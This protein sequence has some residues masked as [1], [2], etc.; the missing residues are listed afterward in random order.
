MRCRVLK[1]VF[2]AAVLYSCDDS[3][4]YFQSINSPPHFEVI[5]G[6]KSGTFISDSL[7]MSDA[8]NVFFKEI[9]LVYEDPNNNVQ[10]LNISSTTGDVFLIQEDTILID[11]FVVVNDNESD[12]VKLELL[13]FTE[14][15]KQLRFELID[16]YEQDSVAEVELFVFENIIPVAVETHVIDQTNGIINFDLSQSYDR[17][18]IYGGTVVQYELNFNGETLLRNLPEFTVS[19]SEDVDIYDYSVRVKDNNGDFSVTIT[20]RININE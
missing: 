10:Q 12:S 8:T 20:D 13:S 2:I 11:E 4:D 19:Y 15:I 17:D 18:G 14:G 6:S 3:A 1:Y 7:K 16:S 5:V 9:F